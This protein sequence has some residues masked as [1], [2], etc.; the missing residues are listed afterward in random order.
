MGARKYGIVQGS[1]AKGSSRQYVTMY[2]SAVGFCIHFPLLPESILGARV[3]EG[4]ALLAFGGRMIL[5]CMGL[6]VHCRILTSLTLLT[7]CKQHFTITDTKTSP[8]YPWSRHYCTQLRPTSPGYRNRQNKVVSEHSCEDIPLSRNGLSHQRSIFLP[9]CSCIREKKK[10]L[11]L[12]VGEEIAMFKRL[13]Q[14]HGQRDVFVVGRKANFKRNSK[15]EM[16]WRQCSEELTEQ[17]TQ[18]ILLL[19]SQ[20]GERGL[21]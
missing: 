2:D 20:K 5:C 11:A 6:S 19:R 10:Q 13:H 21:L 8:V 7:K 12:F 3:L 1:V 9:T 18:S 14:P 16:N 4:E 15:T 17:M